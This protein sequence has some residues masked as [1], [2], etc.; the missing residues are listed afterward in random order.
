[1][2]SVSPIKWCCLLLLLEDVVAWEIFS[3]DSR[4]RDRSLALFDILSTLEKKFRRG[5]QVVVG[6]STI[7]IEAAFSLRGKNIL[8][9]Q[10]GCWAVVAVFGYTIVLA[11]GVIV[12]RLVA[13]G[14]MFCIPFVAG[15]LV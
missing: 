13:T 8:V 7:F 12:A 4:K 1:M 6:R 9:Q 3:R 15:W 11:G 14:G 2:L 10:R 5:E